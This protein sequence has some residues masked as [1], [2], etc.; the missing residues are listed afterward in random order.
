[1]NATPPRAAGPLR[2]R[3]NRCG[4]EVSLRDT[5]C[6]ECGASDLEAL[7][8]TRSPRQM[9]ERNVSYMVMG[10]VVLVPVVLFALLAALWRFV[11]GG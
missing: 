3:C 1:M 11:S 4:A 9:R 2:Y 7:S 8:Y 6:P 5:E 10:F